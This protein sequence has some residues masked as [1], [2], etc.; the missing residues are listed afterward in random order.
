MD[1]SI[2]SKVFICLRY[3]NFCNEINNHKHEIGE[4]KGV[5][6]RN[7]YGSRFFQEERHIAL[8]QAGLPSNAFNGKHSKQNGSEAATDTVDTP[9]IKSII[10]EL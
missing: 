5:S 2:Q 8:Q 7:N 3:F 4:H 1:G 9:Y 10:K 6:C